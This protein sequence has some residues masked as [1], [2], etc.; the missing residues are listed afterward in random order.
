MVQVILLTSPAV[1]G[2]LVLWGSFLLLSADVLVC[3]RTAFVCGRLQF[4]Q[5]LHL[6]RLFDQRFHRFVIPPVI[7]L[8]DP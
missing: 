5:A 4:A 8:S 2:N 3:A 7:A 6:R 1:K